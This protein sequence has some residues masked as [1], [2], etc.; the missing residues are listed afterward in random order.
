MVPLGGPQQVL[1]WGSMKVDS[2]G[3]PASKAPPR[4]FLQGGPNGGDRHG[5]PSKSY[6]LR[7]PLPGS[8]PRGP[9]KVVPSWESPPW[10]S[11][12]RFPLIVLFRGHY[13]GPLRFALQA[14][15]F[16][17]SHPGVPLQGVPFDS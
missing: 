11:F 13:T 15:P 1:P 4:G 7:E 10:G 9:L 8:L 17:G 2:A 16:K 6:N 5:L 3:E 12:H 14:V